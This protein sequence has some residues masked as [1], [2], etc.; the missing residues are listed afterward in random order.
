MRIKSS[1]LLIGRKWRTTLLAAALMATCAVLVHSLPQNGAVSAQT[2]GT[3]ICGRTQQVRDAILDK[4]TKIDCA[5]VTDTH[6]SGV[7]GGLGLNAKGIETLQASD[8]QGLSSLERLYLESNSLKTLPADVFDGLTNLT[9]LY[10][11]RNDLDSLPSD[12]FQ[13]LTNLNWL[14]LNFNELQTLPD[15]VFDGL[16]NLTWLGLNGNDL[17]SLPDG[18]FDD[19]SSLGQ[20]YLNDNDLTSLPDGVFGKL[21]SPGNTELERQRSE[22]PSRR[23]IQG[24]DQPGVAQHIQQPRL[25]VHCHGG[26]GA[27]G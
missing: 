21:S 15:G 6:L 16:T 11:L 8:F 27:T 13:D 25:A 18:V 7:T 1:L 2:D 12:V 23:R 9:E 3:G 10:L 14:Y 19:L 4:L 24:R 17:D 20:L 22:L 5:D 26:P